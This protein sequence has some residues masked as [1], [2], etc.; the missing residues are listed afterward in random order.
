MMRRQLRAARHVEP[1]PCA[2][3]PD[4]ER[5]GGCASVQPVWKLY[6][7]LYCGLWFCLRCGERHFGETR[8]A[9]AQRLADGEAQP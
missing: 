3:A 1:V 9:R 4:G 6:R 8:K 2:G 7:C 5:L